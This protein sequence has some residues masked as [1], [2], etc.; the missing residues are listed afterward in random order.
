MTGWAKRIDVQGALSFNAPLAPYTWFRVGGPAD[1]LFL[2]KDERDLSRFLAAA[3][4]EVPVTVIGVGSNLLVRDGGIAG[5]VIRLGRDFGSI[6][7][8]GPRITA[9]AAALDVMVAKAAQKAGLAGLEFLRGIPGTVGGGL[10]MNAGAYGREFK[11]CLKAARAVDRAGRMHELSLADMKFVYRSSGAPEDLIFTSAAFE[12]V[13]GDPSAIQMRMDEITAA[14]ESTQPVK[15]RTGGSTFKNPPG[16][17]AWA[18][19]D[20]AGCRGLKIG[21]AQVSEQHCNFLINT[22]E[23]KAADI[24][25]LGEE[26]RRRVRETAGVELEWEIKRLGRQLLSS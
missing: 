25:A 24:E 20:A 6:A 18:L 9:G 21:A 4:P 19:I 15:S 17:K 5:A 7:V 26:V 23:A 2:P 1:I 14:R 13:P 8:E 3:P 22:G 11:D 12:G 16:G 10:R